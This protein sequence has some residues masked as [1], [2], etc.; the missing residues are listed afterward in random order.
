MK[1]LENFRCIFENLVRQK[2]AS[3]KINLPKI[4]KMADSTRK[5]CQIR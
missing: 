4:E 1:N 2:I 3:Q 5:T